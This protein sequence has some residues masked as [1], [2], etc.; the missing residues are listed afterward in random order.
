MRVG[1]AVTGS[2]GWSAG[3]GVLLFATATYPQDQPGSAAPGAATPGSQVPVSNLP[4]AAASAEST[5]ETPGEIYKQAMH[6]LDVVRSSLDNWSEAELGALTVGMKKAHDA[7]DAREPREFSG[8][9]LYD[10]IRLCALGQDWE[11]ANA[12][13]QAYIASKLEPHRAQAY[14]LAVNAMVHMNAM[15]LAVETTREMLRVLPYD[16]E[17]AYAV[18]YLKD[19]LD[20]PLLPDIFRLFRGAA[21]GS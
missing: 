13:A 12:A 11:K 8:E 4:A 14:A 1:R 3:I 2:L 15:D 7:C 16:A 19:D 6:P 20:P 21:T 9:D 10:L 17:V 5:V 18:R